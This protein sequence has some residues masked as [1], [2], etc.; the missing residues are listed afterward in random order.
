MYPLGPVR[1]CIRWVLPGLGGARAG[2]VAQ[3]HECVMA[4]AL[5]TGLHRALRG[6][7]PTSVVLRLGAQRV[8]MGQGE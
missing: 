3:H 6:E 4:V 7:G 5:R 1:T 8:P 2:R